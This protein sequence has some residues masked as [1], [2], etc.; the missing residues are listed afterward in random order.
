M[1]YVRASD[2]GA[3][4]QNV[5]DMRAKQILN[6]LAKMLIFVSLVCA[7][8]LMVNRGLLLD[9]QRQQEDHV[10]KELEN[11]VENITWERR[12]DPALITQVK[13][14]I[15]V[16]NETEVT[17]YGQRNYKKRYLTIG[18]PSVSRGGKL[19]LYKTIQGI[20]DC[21]S[22]N[23][24]RNM[25]IFVFLADDK[26]DYNNKTLSEIQSRYTE[27]IQS[28]LL[29][30]MTV[31]PRVYPDLSNLKQN[32]NDAPA[33]VRWRSKQ[34][35]DFA[36]MFHQAKDLSRYYIHI[37]DDVIVAEKFLPKIERFINA[38]DT[39]KTHWAV[40]RFS[41]LGFI[42]KLIKSRDLEKFAKFILTLYDEQPVDWLLDHF[43]RSMAQPKPIYCAPSLFQHMGD[44][45]SLGDKPKAVFRDKTFVQ[46]DKPKK[47]KKA[48][49]NRS[50]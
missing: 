22:K 18:I 5:C 45:S 14:Y 36:L 2:C 42:G 50:V 13:L 9:E 38:V 47:V 30:V 19:Y 37:E 28:G 26:G 25:T 44:V 35:I 49:K 29:F 11:I 48:N 31:P 3:R 10:V 4:R 41:K 33:R 15:N 34:N 23:E 7:S 12:I 16:L 24:Q 39:N 32:F 1:R 43:E 27:E 40:L 20:L 21:T 17:I 46:H 8:L 6:K